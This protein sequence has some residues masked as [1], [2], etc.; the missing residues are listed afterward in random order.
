MLVLQGGRDYQVTT[1]DFDR[2]RA[3]LA[4]HPNATLT[5]LPKLN[6]LFMTGEGK[7]TPAEYDRAG[8]V[9]GAV[10]DAVAKFIDGLPQ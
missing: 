2:F 3:A 9:D 6:H 4:G 8:H 10:I 5:L 7:S 1:Q